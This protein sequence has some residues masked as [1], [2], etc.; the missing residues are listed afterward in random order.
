MGVL[1]N[2]FSSSLPVIMMRNKIIIIPAH[3]ET[4]IVSLE[5]FFCSHSSLPKLSSGSKPLS[6][7]LPPCWCSRSISYW[8]LS[9]FFVSESY[10]IPTY[11]RFKSQPHL[12]AISLFALEVV[13]LEPPII[14]HTNIDAPTDWTQN[15]CWSSRVHLQLGKEEVH[16]SGCYQKILL[17]CEDSNLGNLW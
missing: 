3:P 5:S 13:S 4:C 16:L 8:F 11:V 9:I 12:W 10:Q 1:A 14:W 15:E 6:F 2:A 7:L 17:I